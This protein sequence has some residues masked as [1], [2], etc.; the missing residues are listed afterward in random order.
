MYVK[1]LLLLALLKVKQPTKVS[2]GRIFILL[3]KHI[4]MK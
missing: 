4:A 3:V 2:I 1:K